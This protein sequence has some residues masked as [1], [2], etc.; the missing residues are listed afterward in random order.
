MAPDVG[1]SAG[2]ATLDEARSAFADWL[3]SRAASTVSNAI[4]S[5]MAAVSD[6]VARVADLPPPEAVPSPHRADPDGDP[7]RE[8]SQGSGDGRVSGEE[9]RA[10]ALDVADYHRR[11]LDRFAPDLLERAA[12]RRAELFETVNGLTTEEIALPEA[13]EVDAGPSPLPPP[14]PVVG[15]TLRQRAALRFGRGTR[16]SVPLRPLARLYAAETAARLEPMLND[17]AR[18][19]SLALDG[20]RARLHAPGGGPSPEDDESLR[21]AMDGAN[22]ALETALREVD[23][24]FARALYAP[25]VNVD[26]ETVEETETRARTRA[27]RLLEQWQDFEAALQANTRSEAVLA[28]TL[29]HLEALRHETAARLDR[30]AETRGES[31]LRALAAGLRRL[32]G[33]AEREVRDRGLEALP[34]LERHAAGLFQRTGAGFAAGLNGAL[35][36]AAGRFTDELAGIPDLVPPELSISEERI[37]RIPPRPETLHLR[38]A[39][40]ERLFRSACEGTLPRGVERALEVLATELEGVDRELA[41]LRNAVDFHMKAP[42]RSDIAKGRELEELVVGILRRSASQVEELESTV[43]DLLDRLV[44]GIEGAVVDEADTIRSA[45]ADREFLRM[46]SEIA[47]EEA[48]R[49]LSRGLDR[50]RR[51]VDSGIRVGARGWGVTR[52]ALTR[53]RAWTQRQLR[54]AEVDRE[55]MLDSLQRSILDDRPQTVLPPLYRQLFDVE[56]EVPWDELLVAREEGMATLERAFERWSDG[57]AASVV[58]RGEKGSGR[59]TLVRIATDHLL[60]GHPIHS[61]DLHYT[62]TD[63]ADL[64][65]AIASAFEVEA[66]DWKALENALLDGEPA[67]GIL[68]DAHHLF[69][70]ALG[71][72]GVLEAFLQFVTVTQQR[73]FWILTIDEYAWNYLDRAVGL[74]PHFT[75]EV[76]TTNLAAAR[77]EEAVMARHEVSGYGLRFETTERAVERRLID[78]FLRRPPESELS[79]KER[80]RK[81]FFRDLNQIAEGNIFM[82]LFYWLRSIDRVDDND[83]VL[84]DPSIIDV[85]FLDQLPLPAL[86]TIAAIILHGGLS[87][88]EHE[89]I[90]QLTPAESRLQLAS[91]ADSHLIFRS[92]RDGEYKIN[93]V[94]YRPFIRLLRGKNVF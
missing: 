69:I 20:I 43:R 28:R 33:Q 38:D 31:P 3:E 26:P 67:I 78:R 46:R 5:Y 7:L 81:A 30:I 91:L 49:Q 8:G 80:R 2:P 90:F 6:A 70:R 63:A 86:H 18:I 16:R 72:F 21:I 22:A 62:V 36:D 32:A 39:P 56:G 66:A 40:V 15:P 17:V 93:K 35:R 61:V 50:S 1:E 77:L 88:T 12:A 83:L 37:E 84:K 44:A 94:L 54:T 58:V 14:D 45:I 60:A 71:G 89:R 92:A 9:A 73:V 47:E 68:E 4:E 10:A 41:R 64:I 27:E 52:D 19:Q 87:P 85:E 59:T 53:T 55:A 82:A 57:H 51:I 74:A 34:D 11:F 23:D 75:H 42:V 48:V 79:L 76:T 25:A 29:S 13:I 65:A 24:A